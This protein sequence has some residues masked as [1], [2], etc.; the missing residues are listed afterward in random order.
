MPSEG[1]GH[2]IVDNLKKTYLCVE[3]EI[4]RSKHNLVVRGR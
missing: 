2:V 1:C 3:F 4:A